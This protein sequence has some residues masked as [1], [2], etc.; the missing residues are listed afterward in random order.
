M[1]RPPMTLAQEPSIALVPVPELGLTRASCVCGRSSEALTTTEAAE[2]AELHSLRCPVFLT[3]ARE[4]VDNL[5]YTLGYYI[6]AQVVDLL[7]Q[8]VDLPAAM[9]YLG[10]WLVDIENRPE[11]DG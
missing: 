4:R 8:L 11:V 1:V 2:W 10:P 7:H 9:V 5:G 6:P 3:W